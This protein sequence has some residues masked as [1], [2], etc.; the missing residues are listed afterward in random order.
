MHRQKYFKQC[1]VNFLKFKKM[2]DFNVKRFLE[3]QKRERQGHCRRQPNRKGRTGKYTYLNKV[4]QME[5][6]KA[7]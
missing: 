3:C 1:M 7:Q 5:K 6:T 2:K 4:N